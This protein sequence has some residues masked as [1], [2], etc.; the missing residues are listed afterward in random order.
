[1]PR[2]TDKQPGAEASLRRNARVFAALGDETRIALLA[3]LSD[4]SVGEHSITRLTEGEG[5]SR[6]SITKHLRVLARAGLVRSFRK[7]RERCFALRPDP[8]DRA[9]ESLEHL[10]R[11]WDVALN[12]LKSKLEREQ[13]ERADEPDR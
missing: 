5:V 8:L 4:Q 9:R 7:G 13:S 1:M 6:Q 3:K 11:Q 12:R 2:P 10:S